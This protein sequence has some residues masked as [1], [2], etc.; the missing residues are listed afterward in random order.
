VHVRLAR[1]GSRC[2]LRLN[3]HT[4]ELGPV[5]FEISVAGIVIAHRLL[6]PP[7]ITPEQAAGMAV[8]RIALLV[9]V[10]GL[11]LVN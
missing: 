4:N 9:F 1:S 2:R 6:Y 5:A 11:Y 8:F 3:S 7:Q 10:V